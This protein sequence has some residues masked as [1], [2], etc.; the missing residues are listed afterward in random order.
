V[1]PFLLALP[2]PAQNLSLPLVPESQNLSAYGKE[3]GRRG[4]LGQWGLPSGRT[5]RKNG[6]HWIQTERG[7][8]VTQRKHLSAGVRQKALS[9]G[10]RVDAR[11]T[12]AC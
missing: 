9:R 7:V 1:S 6:L 8:S 10:G 3:I 4:S 2:T 11:K 12:L 5:G